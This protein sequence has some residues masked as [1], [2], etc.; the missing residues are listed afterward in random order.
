MTPRKYLENVHSLFDFDLF[1]LN[2]SANRN[3]EPDHN[4]LSNFIRCRYYSPNSFH[5]E[6]SKLGLNSSLNVQNSTFSIFHNNISSL[7][8]NLENLQVHVLQQLDF[9]FSIIGITE[10]RITNDNISSFNYNIPGYSFEFVPTPL[11][12][13]GVG[14][15][16]RDD[17]NYYVI[18][19]TSEEPF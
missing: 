7:R 14:M 10:T 12:A 8:Q 6:F 5:K 17:Y 1:S 18:E 19:K 9:P 15:Y 13:G 11:S 2:L 3:I 4:F 16:I